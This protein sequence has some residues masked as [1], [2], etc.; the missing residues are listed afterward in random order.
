MSALKHLNLEANELC[1]D[2]ASALAPAFSQMSEL[3]L[4]I[5]RVN[6]LG[7]RAASVLVPAIERMRNLRRFEPH[8]LFDHVLR[9]ARRFTALCPPLIRRLNKVLRVPPYPI[10]EAILALACGFRLINFDFKSNP[11]LRGASDA[12]RGRR[13]SSAP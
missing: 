13:A 8:R 2:G 1:D 10:A 11:K 5:L 3:Q 7:T 4:L 9:R 6:G 12:A